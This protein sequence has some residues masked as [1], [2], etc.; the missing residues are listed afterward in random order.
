MGGGGGL[1]NNRRGW[2]LLKMTAYIYSVGLYT[3]PRAIN[4]VFFL[5]PRSPQREKNKPSS[6][7][8][9]FLHTR[10]AAVP[11]AFVRHGP[12]FLFLPSTHTYT[13]YI[14]FF[15]SPPSNFFFSF[16]DARTS[17]Q[18]FKVCRPRVFCIILFFLS[19]LMR[20]GFYQP[21]YIIYFFLDLGAH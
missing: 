8:F 10:E 16:L 5:S 17:C 7:F 21:P 4:T 14:Y 9:F 12:A 15:L 2:K 19:S 20:G 18:L 6:I 11:H 1:C 3:R 13:A